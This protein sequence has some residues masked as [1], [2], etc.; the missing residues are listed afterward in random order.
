MFSEENEI[1]AND[2][3]GTYFGFKNSDAGIVFFLVIQLI[4][5]EVSRFWARGQVL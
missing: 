5:M 4:W 2:G 3:G 1:F